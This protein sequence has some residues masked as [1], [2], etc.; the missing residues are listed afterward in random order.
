MRTRSLSL[1][2]ASIAI[3][4]VAGAEIDYKVH[5]MPDQD[6]VE[7]HMSF[8]SQANGP[9]TVQ[10]PNWMPGLYIL[11]PTGNNVHGFAATDG[12]GQSLSVTHPDSNTWSFPA[13]SDGSVNVSYSLPSHVGFGA[14]GGPRSNENSYLQFSGP[15][16]YLYVAGRKQEPCRVSFDTPKGWPVMLGLD[17]VSGSRDTFSAP[18]YDVLA[19]NPVSTGDMIVDSYVVRGRPHAIVLQGPAKNEVDRKELLRI[20]K[21]IS[22]SETDFWNDIP[23][24]KYDWLFTVH[25]GNRGG[26]G[27]EHLSSTQIGLAARIDEGTVGL[28]AHEYF[29]LWNVKRVRSKDLG[30]F[31]YTKLPSTG[32]LWWLEGVTDYYAN[33]IP[34][35]YSEWDRRLFFDSIRSNYRA[36]E[37]NPAHLTVS[38][39]E[40]SLKVAEASGG[41][42][43]SNG[44]Q[45]S[46]YNLGWLCGLCLD[47][48]IRSQSRGKH[49][50]D[51]VAH[52]LFA[53]CR[54]DRP[55]F[56]KDEIRRQCVRFGGPSLG[57]FYDRIVMKPGELPVKEELEKAGFVLSSTGIEPD[58][59]ASPEAKELGDQWLARKKI[60]S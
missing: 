9:I 32:A 51:D 1:L 36:V 30:P 6:K 3:A 37:Q 54:N 33:L 41:R 48:E 42:G 55:G 58:P 13:P 7:V 2:A 38:P 16:L 53:L 8:R 23:Y 27:L 57:E 17:A 52:A 31:D 47:L 21:F 25:S 44:Y 29:H 34:Y 15:M 60:S 39:Y 10:M 11:M 18:T 20:C 45:I 19:D 46:Y 40:A 49:S 28:L 26:G 12:R 14:V 22:A 24:H 50:L 5:V 43:N 59:S 56:E 35:R 4:P